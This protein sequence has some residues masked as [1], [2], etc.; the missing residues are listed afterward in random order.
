MAGE[1]NFTRIPPEST[2]ARVYMVHSMYIP[3]DGADANFDWV[4]GDRYYINGNSGDSITVHVHGVFRDAG[5][6]SGVLSVHIVG[7]DR[8]NNLTPINDQDIRS[9]S[10]TGTVRAQVNGTINTT[11]AFH[12]VFIPT[13]NIMG[14]DN[15]EHGLDVDNLGSANVRFQE[16][17]PQLDA[18]GKLRTSGATMLG[19]YVFGGEAKLNDNF[20]TVEIDGGYVDYDNTRKSVKV[21]FDHTAVTTQTFGANTSNTYHP[22]IPGSSHLWQGTFL[23][24]SSATGDGTNGALRRWGLFD[25]ENG[26]FFQLGKDGHTA[27]TASTT[28]QGFC[29]VIR[30]STSGSKTETIIQQSDFNGDK[31]DGTG[32]SQLS[33]DLEKNNQYWIDIQWHGAGRVRFGTY[34]NGTRIVMHTYYAGNQ[35]TVAMSQTASLPSCTSIKS[36]GT[37]LTSLYI[38]TWAQSVWSETELEA[39]E[40]GKPATYASTH[41]T[42]TANIDSDWQYLFSLSPKEV[43]ADGRVDHALFMPTSISAYGFDQTNNGRNGLEAVIDLKAEINSVLNHGNWTDIA[44]TNIQ[45]SYPAAGDSAYEGGAIRL[46][47]MFAGRYETDTTDT[48]NNFQYGAIKNFSED[49]GTAENTITGATQTDP[50]VI[51]T[52]EL[53]KFKNPSPHTVTFP[54][55]TNRYQGKLEINDVGGMTQLNGN[56]Y[57]IKPTSTT[58]FELYTDSDGSGNIDETTGVD[59]T[60]FDAYTS[61]GTIKGFTGS[62]LTWN[63]YAKSRTNGASNLFDNVKLMVTVNWKEIIQ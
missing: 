39:T 50:V 28:D 57:L 58:T 27:G 40:F 32:K 47:E 36:A 10:F 55:N 46:Q 38:E 37:P 48:Y 20:S 17:Q 56:K 31:L 62:R 59:G 43:L 34:L 44:G 33:F 21:G 15:P 23:L 52:G 60:A 49:G 8:F 51:T 7:Q 13:T 1:R 9:D 26:F 24:N 45:Y 16:G 42:V 61:G 2:G 22:Y 6:T 4:I 30:T 5:A 11:N 54:L 19:N 18:W 35:E 12:D 14:Y 29:V 25:A 3:Y 63:F 41:Q 53:L